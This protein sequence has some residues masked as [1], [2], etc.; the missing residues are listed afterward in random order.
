MSAKTCSSDLS[1]TSTGWKRWSAG[2]RCNASRVGEAWALNQ[3]PFKQPLVPVNQ[4]RSRNGRS[5]HQP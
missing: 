5:G 1:A 3:V 2:T 4:C